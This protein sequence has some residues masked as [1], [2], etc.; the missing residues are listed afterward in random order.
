MARIEI[1]AGMGSGKTSLAD[2]L[3]K[4]G[5]T[6]IEEDFENNPFLEQI[7]EDG[8][9]NWLEYG[10]TNVMIHYN[11]LRKNDDADKDYVFDFSILLDR[12]YAESHLEINAISEKELAVYDK[13]DKLVREKMPKV[14]LRI[15][16]V[17]KPEEQ[18]RR[19]LE[20]GREYEKDISLDF[21]KMMARN[22]KRFLDER[23][24]DTKVLVIDTGKYDYVNNPVHQK[25][26]LNMIMQALG[27]GG[28]N[29]KPSPRRG[30]P[31]PGF[32]P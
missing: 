22:T 20:R 10:I 32:R 27:R 26:V 30:G 21:L 8:Q 25:I 16:L 7:Y 12:A 2:L 15:H 9:E 17:C 24:N 28:P 5:F 3:V 18:K 4:N 31:G 14:D 23:G 19:I 1:L 11:Q 6:H 29:I 13:L